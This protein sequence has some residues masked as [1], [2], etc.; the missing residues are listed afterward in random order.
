MLIPPNTREALHNLTHVTDA[1]VRRLVLSAPCKSSDLDPIP[2]SLEKDCID[3]LVSPIM[4]IVHLSLSKGC[5]PSHFKSALVS[6][7]LKK[8]T[9]NRD[10]L[11]NYRP[12]SNLSFLS[13]ILE[14]VLASHLNPHIYS[15]HI[16]IDY[17]SA[18]RKFLSTEMVFLKSTMIFAH[19]Y[20]Q[21]VAHA[22][23]I[24]GICG[25]F[26]VILIWIVQNYL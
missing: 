3:I 9:P 22:F 1:E 8:P 5:F 14:K 20:Q 18:Y 12:V 6:H 4:S 24:C 19:T 7:L 11:K 13:K 25:V 26:A 17:Q 21:S 10:D 2:T 23:T 15:S 16:S